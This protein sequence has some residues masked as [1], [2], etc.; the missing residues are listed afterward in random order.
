M[1]PLLDLMNPQDEPRPMRPLYI[2]KFYIDPEAYY[3]WIYIHN[4]IASVTAISFFMCGDMILICSTQHAC[5]IFEA[6]G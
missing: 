1:T 6:I 4:C 3:K 5:S 2:A